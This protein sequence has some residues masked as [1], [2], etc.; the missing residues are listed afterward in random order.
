[1]QGNSPV[2]FTVSNTPITTAGAPVS[3]GV[4]AQLPPTGASSS[5]VATSQASGASSGAATGNGAPAGA[6]ASGMG[7]Q[8]IL[9]AAVVL[10]VVM[11]IM[12]GRRERKKFETMMNSIKKNDSVRTVGGI[13][14]SVV[15]VKPDVVVLK[16]DEH[17]NT[18][19]TVAR[20]KIEAVLKESVTS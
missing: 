14:G 8:L 17:S 5:E 9:L 4:I 6:G 3:V 15:E 12:G 10:F 1:M 20:S 16:V 11:T 19:I 18:K 7:F 13:I 2:A